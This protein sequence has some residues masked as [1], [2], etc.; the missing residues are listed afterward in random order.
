[1]GCRGWQVPEILESQEWGTRPG[2]SREKSHL[3]PMQHSGRNL[4]LRG[5]CRFLKNG[6]SV[7]E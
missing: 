3:H 5:S 2:S 4:L 7:R 1:M 6:S